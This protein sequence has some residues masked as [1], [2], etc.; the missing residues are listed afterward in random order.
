MGSETLAFKSEFVLSAPLRSNRRPPTRA[1]GVSLRGKAEVV[2]DVDTDGV[3]RS[4]RGARIRREHSAVK[5]HESGQ[6]A[7]KNTHWPVGPA[8]GPVCVSGESAGD[9]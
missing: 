5:R 9:V 7:A 8:G 6:T 4:S 1:M 3:S 2:E